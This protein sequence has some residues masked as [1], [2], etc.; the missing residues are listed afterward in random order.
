MA[1]IA[2]ASGFGRTSA[3]PL[4]L[5]SQV[6]D[7]TA[8]NAIPTGV[9]Y[10]GMTVY[11]VSEQAEYILRGGILDT[12][13]EASGGSGGGGAVVVWNPDVNAPLPVMANF[14]LTIAMSLPAWQ[15]DAAEAQKLIGVIKV[16]FGY[17]PGKPITMRA[18]FT[19]TDSTTATVLLTAASYLLRKDT[20]STQGVPWEQLS[21]NTAIAQGAALAS[22]PREVTIDISSAIGEIESRA[23]SPGDMIVIVLSRGTDTSTQPVIFFP[24]TSEVLFA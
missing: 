1:G 17:K 12:N 8:R 22:R 15:F 18:L 3:Q 20:D 21:S 7:I 13:W 2:V 24:S 5:Y 16:P 19:S 10:E 11:V 9:R 23:V 14:P 6:A 4:D